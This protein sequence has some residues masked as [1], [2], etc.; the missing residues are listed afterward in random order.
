[1]E[2][3]LENGFDWN[4]YENLKSFKRGE[5][6]IHKTAS[7]IKKLYTHKEVLQKERR[8]REFEATQESERTKLERGE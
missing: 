1:M 8:I 2:N 5:Q 4:L 6:N 3:V 7:N